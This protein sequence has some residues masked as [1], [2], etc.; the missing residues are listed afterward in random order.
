M[1]PS[2]GQGAS[3]RGSSV[4]AGGSEGLLATDDLFWSAGARYCAPD[5]SEYLPAALPR[6]LSQA[7]SRCGKQGPISNAANGAV[8]IS[9]MMRAL[10]VVL[11]A[12]DQEVVPLIRQLSQP[13]R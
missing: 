1:E 5:G 10:F 4:P 6:T 13:V 8:I 12:P 3:G 9:G 11:T 2:A 7:P